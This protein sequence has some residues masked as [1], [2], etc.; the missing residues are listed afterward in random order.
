[1]S[2]IEPQMYTLRTGW[3]VLIRTARPFDALAIHTITAQAI[4]EGGYHISEPQEFT[5]TLEDEEAWIRQHA[6]RP[7][8]AMLVA[9][10]GKEVVGLIHFEPGDGSG[11]RIVENWP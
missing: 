4:A 8:E 9:E 10:V 2:T 6:E 5:V 1:M 11:R 7:S 3:T